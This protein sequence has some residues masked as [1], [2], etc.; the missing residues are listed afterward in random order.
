MNLRRIL[1][2][3]ALGLFM[4]A[5]AADAR[6]VYVLPPTGTSSA[7]MLI[8]N[9]QIQLA[10]TV[11]VPAGSF[12]VLTNVP[13]DK[14]IV[15]ATNN[16]AAVSFATLPNGPVT[17]LSLDGQPATF[18]AVTP[19]G[20]RLLVLAGSSPGS[21]YIIDA[22][23]GNIQTGGKISINGI[24]REVVVTQDSRYAFIVSSGSPTALLTV[25][26][27]S[28]N[29]IV[30]QT[31]LAQVIGALH[32]SI[33][34]LGQ[35]Y[36]TGQYRMIEFD[37][38]PPFA[39]HARS[40]VIS[41]PGRL[42]FSPDGRYAIAANELLNG[43]SLI[44]I[45]LQ[46]KGPTTAAGTE[47]SK[48]LVSTSSNTAVRI[49]DIFPVNAT[50]AIAY[51]ALDQKM[52]GISY[53]SLTANELALSGVGVVNGVTSVTRTDEFPAARNLYYTSG[54][55]LSRFDLVQNTALGITDV[56]S[57]T[58][59]FVP[60]PNTGATPKT[61][62]TY[63]G[64][65]TSVKPG[66]LVPYSVRAVDAN[67]RPVY[68][69]SVSFSSETAVLTN[70]A[71]TTNV[72]GYA[73]VVATGPPANG[74]FVVTALVG[75][76][77][78]NLTST[79][80]G[81][82]GGGTGGG[83][84][85]DPGNVAK[86]IKVSGDGQ[87][88]QNQFTV[89]VLPLVVKVVDAKGAPIA[90]KEVTWS[91]S[92]GIQFTALPTPTDANGVTQMS[93]YP[94]GD[95]Q[96]ATYQ[97]YIATASVVGI[98]STTFSI[99]AFPNGQF[100]Q[101]T[102]FIRKP[103]QDVRSITMKLG[104]KL[105]GAVHAIVSSATG[106]AIPN[107]G[108][109]VSTPFTDPTQ[110]PVVHCD[111][112]TALNGTVLTAAN[113][114]VDCNLVAE[115]K[116]GSTSLLINVGEQRDFSGYTITVTPGDPVAPV[117]VQGN[118]QTGKPGVTLPLALTARIVDPSGNV[119]AGTAV[120]WD[121]VTANSMT[122]VNTISAADSNGLVSTKV[123]LGPTPGKF[124]V[125]LKAGANETLFDVTI[126]TSATGFAKV[127]GDGQAVAPINTA[128]AQPL[129]VKV[130]DASG[131]GVQGAAVT[132]TTTGSVTLSATSSVTGA[133]G[134]ASVIATAGSVPGAITVTAAVSN[135][136]SQTFSLQSRLP[137]PSVTATS[138]ANFASG[139][140]GVSPGLLVQIT[141]AGL[142]PGVTGQVNANIL[143]GR[144]PL[145]LS[146]V[147][148]N[149]QWTGGSGYAPIYRVANE[150]GVESVLVQAP[151][152]I[153]GT[154]VNAVVNV[155]GGSTNVLA[156][157]VSLVS[158]GV[159]EDVSGSRR[160]AVV[161]RSDGQTVTPDTPARPGETLR[162]YAIGL[163]QTSPTA[164]TNQVGTPDQNVLA[165]IA[166]GLDNA[167]IQVVSAQM[168]ENLIGV[169]EIVFVVPVGTTNGDHP[170][171]FVMEAVPGQPA[172]ANGSILA[173]Q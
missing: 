163:G 17:S 85:T 52:F 133:D 69:A 119:L 50:T 149:F 55:K 91:A 58:A 167:G 100:Y 161:I 164:Y 146:G 160:A 142:A 11:T 122:L 26:D 159:L 1:S 36:I 136:P 47:I 138:F 2:P 32:A 65:L 143:A 113:G 44:C 131:N 29:Q 66:D 117:I 56:G 70:A 78:A 74:D 9:E 110:G 6:Y 130:T 21:L 170:L 42:H 101:P 96:G 125:R 19:D 83:G 172:Y 154:T 158:P 33:S 27:L 118:N 148:V 72:D 68:G 153:T 151:F 43:Y 116:T 134:R 40:E 105:D 4:L 120:T 99:S 13:G 109:R 129:V 41:N 18:G 34:P 60:Q 48:I 82:T 106:I 38:R 64:G 128:F 98:G 171:G 80:T 37:G 102:I 104:T 132:W 162:M 23:N 97:G 31:Q 140:A 76:L 57:G 155:S 73:W 24:P 16:V 111:G 168:A 46:V 108:L 139:V 30:N 90:G 10:G 88:L 173:V 145:T 45:D 152:E 89:N 5:A 126:E 137:G 75:S 77:T 71:S 49:D 22:V 84:T 114:E 156:I 12:Q 165:K 28:T 121:L 25:V 115:G 3:V 54:G 67:G 141:G 53:P 7:Q 81:G 112:Q 169:Y 35:V 95:F 92:P 123:I 8:H 86:V 157:P 147:T 59:V 61:L 51:S 93:I 127:S 150:N 107:V 94:N 135:L 15:L 166:V 14:A 20:L 124:K 87:L 63:G 62:F 79:I 39:E 144:L 103:T